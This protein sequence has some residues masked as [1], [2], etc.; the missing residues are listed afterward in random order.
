MTIGSIRYLT[1]IALTPELEQQQ[2]S[3]IVTNK[4]KLSLSTI[5]PTVMK[6][7]HQSD[8]HKLQMTVLPLGVFK[9]FIHLS[10]EASTSNNDSEELSRFVK[11]KTYS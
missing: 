4:K 8:E 6:V 7:Y 9:I 1:S 3:E 5:V 11:S 10:T 2:R